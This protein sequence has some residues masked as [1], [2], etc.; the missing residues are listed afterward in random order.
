MFFKYESVKDNLIKYQHLPCNKHYSN[1]F[2]EESK[3]K[4]ENIFKFSN[5]NFNKSIFLLR[6]GVY[7]HEY[8]D[9]WEK[10]NE[11]T[12][13]EKEKFYSKL[14]METIKD[15]AEADYICAESVCKD[16]EIKNLGNI[17]ICIL[18][19]MYYF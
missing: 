11:T 12:L 17:M 9:D 19:V 6:K 2:D 14:I 10:F 8:M 16:F 18:E 3:K 7:P 1:K 15:I 4:F 13:P 5:N